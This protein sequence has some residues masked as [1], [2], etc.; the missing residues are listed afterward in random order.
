MWWP[1]GGKKSD[2]R[3]VP[4]PTVTLTDDEHR[5]CEAYL[6]SAVP[7]TEAG[8][9]YMPADAAE[10]FKR[11][12][13]AVCMM[14]RAQRF[15]M[16]RQFTE[17]CEAASKACCIDPQCTHFYEFGRIL[18][19]AGK[20]VDAKMAFAEFLRRYQADQQY[21][22]SDNPDRAAKIRSAV[23]PMVSYARNKVGV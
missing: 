2:T 13:I 15:A 11:G 10:V 4:A 7:Q 6:K 19:A 9:W 18:E 1:F 14:G 12:L 8:A 3:M 20:E 21:D 5:E 23:E 22:A 16:L 17:A